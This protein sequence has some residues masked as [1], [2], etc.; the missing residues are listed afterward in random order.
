MGTVVAYSNESVDKLIRRA[1]RKFDWV[2]KEV[3]SRQHHKK[4]ATL[5]K[6]EKDEARKREE[7]LARKNAV[8]SSGGPNGRSRKK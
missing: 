3:R 5:R 8:V 6:E 1:E 4:K 2:K 7:K